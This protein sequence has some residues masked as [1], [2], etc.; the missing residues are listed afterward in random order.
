VPAV[1]SVNVGRA[2]PV[3]GKSGLSAI[4]KRPVTGRVGV[5][6][7]G[8]DG[9]EQADRQNHGGLE[10]AV[11]AYA[12][13]DLKLWAGRLDRG[14]RFG[15]FGENLS[16]SGLDVTAAV[17]GEIWRIGTAV[18]QVSC[19]RIPCV[20]FQNWLGEPQWVKRFTEDGRPGAYLRVL[21][22]GDIGADDDIVVEHRPAHGVTIGIAFRAMTTD[23]SL[24]PRLLDAP[25][26]APGGHEFAMRNA[27][28]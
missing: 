15:E 23:R 2:R 13:E 20:V 4:D 21:E 28:D 24:I 25:E 5:H 11:Y 17:I 19:P 12:S 7:L 16:T 26:L 27:S 22:E 6:A 9:D 14:F 1:L 8:L 3:P 10:Q 18:L